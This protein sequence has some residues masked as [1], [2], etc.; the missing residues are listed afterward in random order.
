MRKERETGREILRYE[1]P[2]S[3]KCLVPNVFSFQ[4]GDG[5]GDGDGLAWHK[6]DTAFIEIE[7]YSIA[8]I[9]GAEAK[10]TWNPDVADTI[11]TPTIYS[12][13]NAYCRSPASQLVPVTPQPRPDLFPVQSKYTVYPK[14]G[15]SSLRL[16]S[17]FSLSCYLGVTDL[18]S[19]LPVFL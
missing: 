1:R 6:P 9:L 17:D 15:L 19:H 12:N 7:S 14:L 10:K 13:L 3:M 18:Q 8:S 16:S 11:Y 5:G 2:C 4:G